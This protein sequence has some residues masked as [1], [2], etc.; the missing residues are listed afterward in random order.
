MWK[1]P[2][3]SS[4]MIY[5][6]QNKSACL[7]K[8]LK[9]LTFTGLS[10]NAIHFNIFVGGKIRCFTCCISSLGSQYTSK[11]SNSVSQHHVGAS[12]LLQEATWKRTL[13]MRV[14]RPL[15]RI[16]RA[17]QERGRSGTKRGMAEA[18]WIWIDDV[19]KLRTMDLTWFGRVLLFWYLMAVTHQPVLWS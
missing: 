5:Y 1:T 14:L 16:S 2:L 15:P 18:T 8:S 3:H 17:G 4:A 19:F 7:D 13:S 11:P 10:M 9:R 12:F 6:C